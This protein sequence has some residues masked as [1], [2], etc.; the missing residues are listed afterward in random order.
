MTIQGEKE[1]CQIKYKGG[2]ITVL[3]T[4]FNSISAMPGESQDLLYSI[5][6]PVC[7]KL[8]HPR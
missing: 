7:T 1:D 3:G 2:A 8:L 6:L 5:H 4:V